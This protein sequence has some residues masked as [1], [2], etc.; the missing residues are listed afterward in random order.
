MKQ[1]GFYVD[2]DENLNVLLPFGEPGEADAKRH[3]R[4][5]DEAIDMARAD[6]WLHRTIAAA[7][8]TGPQYKLT[9][10]DWRRALLKR[11]R[12]QEQSNAEPN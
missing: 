6:A 1:S 7:Y 12:D 5:A 9:S 11:Q 3:I 10:R 4:E 2:L 8:E